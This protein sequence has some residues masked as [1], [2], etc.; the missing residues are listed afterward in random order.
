MHDLSEA[1]T[2]YRKY[3]FFLLAIY[4]LGWGFTAYQSIFLGLFLGTVG[5]LYI[6]FSLV[7]KNKQFSQA[8]DE[9]RKVRSLGSVSRMAVAGLAVLIVMEYP[10]QL[11][12]GSTVMGLMTCYFVIMID[13]FFQQFRK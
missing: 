12:L 11:H 4:A 7:R 9:G 1:F 5:S 3:I 6:L 13:F 10:E 8:V 2:R